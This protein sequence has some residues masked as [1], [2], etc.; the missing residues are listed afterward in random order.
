MRVAPKSYACLTLVGE[1][2]NSFYLKLF[3]CVVEIFAADI[4]CSYSK[5][6]ANKAERD[7]VKL[8]EYE[9]SIV[10]STC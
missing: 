1:M 2:K 5:K 9:E 4:V 8:G 10:A 7:R 6:M 3:L